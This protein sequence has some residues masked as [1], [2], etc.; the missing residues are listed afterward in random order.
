MESPGTMTTKLR[1][2]LDEARVYPNP[3]KPNSSDERFRA[4]RLTFSHLTEWTHLRVFNVAGE[5]VFETEEDTPDGELPWDVVNNRGRRLASG[6][7][8]YLLADKDGNTATGR[9]SVIR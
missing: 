6:V 3:F 1:T 9:F 5:L 7:Y 8:I 4:E 2:D